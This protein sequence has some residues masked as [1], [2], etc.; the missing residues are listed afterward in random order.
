MGLHPERPAKSLAAQAGGKAAVKPGEQLARAWG[1]QLL[2]R[3]LGSVAASAV[4]ALLLVVLLALLLALLEL[5]PAQARVRAGRLRRQE[6][7]F[8]S[9]GALRKR[10]DPEIAAGQAGPCAHDHR[11]RCASR[12]WSWA[13]R[14]LRAPRADSNQPWCVIIISKSRQSTGKRANTP[15]PGKDCARVSCQRAQGWWRAAQPALQSI[16]Q[17]GERISPL[18]QADPPMIVRPASCLSSLQSSHK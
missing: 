12:A 14:R 13:V 3:A 18:P 10:E 2:A 15:S 1:G 6:H 5:L 17:R 4:E 7:C 11:S 8:P 9:G 16:L